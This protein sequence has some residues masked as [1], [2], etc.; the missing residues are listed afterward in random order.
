MT[1]LVTL[2]SPHVKLVAI[3]R[4]RVARTISHYY[5]SLKI[6]LEHRSLEEAI[7]DEM[8]ILGDAE[9]LNQVSETYWKTEQ[10]YLW[11]SLYLHLLKR[12]MSLFPKEQ[13]LILNSE[14]LYNAPS[15]TLSKVF[16]FLYISDSELINYPKLNLGAYSQV[17]HHS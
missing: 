16:R 2:S 3:L 8:A 7:A 15:E 10:G 4:N 17:D 14:A 5:M 1:I 12:W 13:F 6:G 11:F 9:S